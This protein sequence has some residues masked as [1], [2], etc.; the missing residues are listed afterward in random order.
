MSRNE[1]PM[2]R[3]FRRWALLS[4]LTLAVTI[5]TATTALVQRNHGR[6]QLERGQREVMQLLVILD[7]DLDD[8]LDDDRGAELGGEEDASRSRLRL[9]ATRLAA[10][11]SMGARR[12]EMGQLERL[13]AALRRAVEE[14]RGART[15]MGYGEALELA[16]PLEKSDEP[17]V[18]QAVE[19]AY[20]LAG[21]AA[22]RR[23]EHE[24]ARGLLDR[25]VLLGGRLYLERPAAPIARVLAASH[26]L[27]ARLEAALGEAER[28]EQQWRFALELYEK[29]RG[30]GGEGEPLQRAL[31]A[32]L[33]ALGD[34][35]M[36]RAR[37]AGAR[38][39]YDRA[40]AMATA[41]RPGEGTARRG[42]LLELGLRR[43]ERGLG[44]SEQCL[45]LLELVTPQLL[46]AEGEAAWR[47]ASRPLHRWLEMCPR[48]GGGG[49][50]ARRLATALQATRPRGEPAQQRESAAA[51]GRLWLALGRGDVSE[52]RWEEARLELN[53]ARALLEAALD[54]R[55]GGDGGGEGERDG[56][57]RRALLALLAVEL[58]LPGLSAAA[59]QERV[60]RCRLVGGAARWQGARVECAMAAARRQSGA[61]RLGSIQQLRDELASTAAADDESPERRRRHLDVL[62]AVT[63]ALAESGEAQACTE[64]R[65]LE[66]RA[67]ELLQQA[68]RHWGQPLRAAVAAGPGG[69]RGGASTPLLVAD[70][71]ERVT[72]GLL[73]VEQVLRAK[74]KCLPSTSPPAP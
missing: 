18:W 27:L 48:L 10:T 6:A 23:G 74:G 62:L 13:S 12:G 52:E 66:R 41:L 53:E 67:E 24:E 37:R 31:V 1:D 50:A 73:R 17:A 28:S 70:A 34:L 63:L 69:A 68:A 15:A 32:A 2:T 47:E 26:G 33:T 38:G 14:E 72:E 29:W 5:A 16:R 71:T 9:E 64:V 42:L 19:R 11:L 7:E 59:V 51:L 45:T 43:M 57:A 54:E 44:G 3:S 58:E 25:A 61:A 30:R 39:F 36:E 55:A 56:D 22:L 20:R 40:M 46:A 60:E 65:R 21:S 8:D 35:E 49:A 4:S